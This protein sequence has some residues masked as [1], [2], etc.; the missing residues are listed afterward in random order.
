MFTVDSTL[1]EVLTNPIGRDL[2]TAVFRQRG[3]NGKL[4]YGRA[5]GRCRLGTLQFLPVHR[6]DR[7]IVRAMLRMMNEHDAPRDAA[8]EPSGGNWWT[9]CVIYK[10]FLRSFM[11]SDGDGVGDVDGLIRMTDYL[12]GLGVDAVM[13]CAGLDSP[14]M[15]GGHDVRSH[16][17]L[18]GCVGREDVEDE[19]I[20][21]VHSRGMKLILEMPA[22][23]TSQEHEWFSG[24]EGTQPVP[25]YYLYRKEPNNWTCDGGGTAFPHKGAGGRWALRLSS[26]CEPELNWDDAGLRRRMAEVCGY[27]LDRGMDGVCLSGAGLISKHEGLPYG[28]EDA[29]DVAGRCGAEHY[30]FG[31]KVQEY[32]RELKSEV[33]APRGALLMGEAPCAGAGMLGLLADGGALDLVITDEHLR[34]CGG[35]RKSGLSIDMEDLKSFLV[36]LLRQRPQGVALMLE[37]E[38]LPRLLS[39]IAPPDKYADTAAKMLATLLLMLKAV[40]VI[41][42][43]EE[44]GMKNVAPEKPEQLVSMYSKVKYAGMKERFGARKAQQE[45]FKDVP[46]QTWAPLR[47]EKKPNGGFCPDRVEPWAAME[48]DLSRNVEDETR[49][50]DSVLNYY[51]TLLELRRRYGAL[52]SGEISFPRRDVK[53]TLIFC[54]TGDGGKLLVCCNLTGEWV[55]RRG[56]WPRGRLLLSNCTE[57]QPEGM[58]PYEADIWLCT[59]D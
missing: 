33:F 7:G 42:Q 20:Q 12:A 53:G 59:D 32:L 3:W 56:E 45:A 49:D 27:W 54:R 22:N 44:L 31:P 15:N 28:S 47:W 40:P 51:Y 48:P 10:V 5:A 38:R 16:R 34:R 46:E 43:G 26:R 9:D 50:P 39:R 35:A 36:P 41:F 19:L 24:G 37:S 2:L 13:L 4:L 1:K 30:I 29:S 8:R 18:N 23:C 58:L 57:P 21:A 11:D 25:Q 17:A 55:D 52:R 14:G 6:L